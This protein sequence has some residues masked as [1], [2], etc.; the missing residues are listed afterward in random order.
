MM[1]ARLL[2]VVVVLALFA[3]PAVAP[4]F[5]VTLMSHVGVSSLVVLGLVLLTGIGGMMSF[6]QAAFVGIAAYTTGWLT[7]ALGWS[8][9]L[10]LIF[11]L[12]LT[13]V[14][15]LAIGVITL[16]LGGHFLP[17]STIAWGLSIYYLFGNLELL[18]RH[19]G[20]L[21]IPPITLGPISFMSQTAM[22]YLIWTF[23]LLA[24]L[25]SLNL[26]DSREGRALRL[27][28]GGAHL[29]G[30]I[31]MDTFGTRLRVF[32]IS[33]IF[34]GIAGWL[35]AHMT[36]FISPAPF[37]V[38]ISIEYLLMAMTGGASHVAGATVG[39]GLVV[40]IKNWLQD[41]LPHLTSNPAQLEQ[42]AFA[43][44]LILILRF[45]R[46]GL[47]PLVLKVVRRTSRPI[48]KEAGLL[49]K[50]Q[51]P[52]PG[53]TVLEVDAVERRFGG[54]I[55]VNKVSF[56]VKAGE[57]VGLIGPNGAGKSTMFNLI[58]GTLSVTSGSVRF[59]G[60]DASRLSQREVAALGCART[61]QHVKLRHGMSLL[62][63]VVSGTYL[64]TRAGYIKSGLRLDRAEEE[65]ARLEALMRLQQVGLAE[66]A[67][68]LAGDLPLGQQRVLEIARALAVDPV[69]LIL[70]EP[71]AGLR[72]KEKDALAALL[73]K[74]RGEGLTI[75]IV[76]HDMDFVM[77]LVDRLVVMVFG[78][79]LREGDPATIRRDPA[80]QEAYLGG[81][82]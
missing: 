24:T 79:K 42:V 39:S 65:R 40:L 26:L 81:L 7:T 34:A 16:R 35:Y 57:I 43:L 29:M 75:L 27:L 67:H 5:L 76:E 56:D 61:F 69:L 3:L 41:L 18:G 71:A 74:L 10:G 32:V 19:S 50:R 45:A 4:P 54:L 6:G 73:N 9:W 72:K 55:A 15:A 31:G 11:A 21:N 12:A 70:D 63:N 68:D 33:G 37:E 8:P 14:S 51:L 48:L 46:S 2:A 44:M 78:Q 66:R 80:V 36:R 1:P 13:A 30:S 59:L 52:A 20:M 62:D 60:R 58:T 49:P 38:K 64:R 53:D 17:L 22:Y 82:A 25:F 28:R 23:A 47:M 77:N